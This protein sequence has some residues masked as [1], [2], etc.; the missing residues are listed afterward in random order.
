[1]L[2]AVPRDVA[3]NSGQ[4]ERVELMA[5]PGRRIPAAP[6]NADGTTRD[7]IDVEA[8]MML[9]QSRFRMTWAEIGGLLALIDNR[10]VAYRE[11]S[12]AGAVRGVSRKRR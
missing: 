7:R 3:S 12:V 1:M 8:A 2:L 10:Q 6:R 11:T 9:R 5:R 4:S